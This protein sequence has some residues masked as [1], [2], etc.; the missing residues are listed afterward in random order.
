MVALWE[1]G[2]LRASF[3]LWVFGNLGFQEAQQVCR[4]SL[5]RCFF[6]FANIEPPISH[7]FSQILFIFR[8]LCHVAE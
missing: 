1:R 3:V 8:L 4:A 7:V 6:F 2:I 5:G